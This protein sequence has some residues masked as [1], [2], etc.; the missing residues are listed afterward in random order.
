LHQ[1]LVNLL[2]NARKYS[3]PGSAVGLAAVVRDDRL[4]ISLSDEGIG[5]PRSQ[6]ERIFEPFHRLEDPS[7]PNV[8]GLGLGLYLVREICHAMDCEVSVESEPGAGSTFTVLVPLA[9]A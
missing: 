1:V 3:V 2:N 9:Q 6:V 8:T 5:I 7:R 4:A